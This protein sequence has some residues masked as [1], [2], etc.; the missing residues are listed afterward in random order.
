MDVTLF[1]Q[2]WNPSLPTEKK[3]ELKKELALYIN[4]LLLHDFEKLVQLLYR[5]DVPEK[6]I[7]KVLEENKEKDAGDLLAELLIK[8]QEEKIALRHTFPPAED[9]P[10]DERW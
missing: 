9:I 7:R 10:E 6:Q 1:M 3:E 5:I 8:R 2:T 4:D